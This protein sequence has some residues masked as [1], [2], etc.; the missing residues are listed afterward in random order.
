[1]TRLKYCQKNTFTQ[2]RGVLSHRGYK[3]VVLCKCQTLNSL[4]KFF[5][6]GRKSTNK[7]PKWKARLEVSP[8]LDRR[9]LFWVKKRVAKLVEELWVLYNKAC[10]WWQRYSPHYMYIYKN[11]YAESF[12]QHGKW[13]Y[14]D[15]VTLRLGLPGTCIYSILWEVFS[16]IFRRTDE[17]IW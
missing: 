14:M 16:Y 17:G 7:E 9:L 3:L 13:N 4:V 5:F 8:R 2:L 10:L 1:M 12:I 6:T 15:W 11:T